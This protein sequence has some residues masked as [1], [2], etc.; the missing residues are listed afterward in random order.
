[1]HPR[2]KSRIFIQDKR[3]ANYLLILCVVLMMLASVYIIISYVYRQR[4]YASMI[5]AVLYSQD[6]DYQ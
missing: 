1:M 3:R 6:S 2:S 5:D 4:E